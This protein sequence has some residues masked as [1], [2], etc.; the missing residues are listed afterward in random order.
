MTSRG[1]VVF[2][3]VFSLIAVAGPVGA[4]TGATGEHWVGTWATAAVSA[5]SEPPPQPPSGLPA[6]ALRFN[7]QTFRQ[8]VRISIGGER[9][10]VVLTNAFGTRALT[11]DGAHLALRGSG[12]AIAADRTAR[13]PS[14]G[15]RPRP[16]RRAPS[17]SAIR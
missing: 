1:R 9:V 16:F 11:I 14:V 12:T 2:G 5:P 15:S 6:P 3:L 7:N 8:F 10:R 13:S 4:Q 17:W